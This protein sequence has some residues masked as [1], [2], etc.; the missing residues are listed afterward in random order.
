MQK[1]YAHRSFTLK[2]I[3]IYTQ[4]DAYM[5][6]RENALFCTGI[7]CIIRAKRWIVHIHTHTHSKKEKKNDR[8]LTGTE[9]LQ[10]TRRSNAHTLQKKKKCNIQR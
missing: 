8:K 6:E 10:R 2:Y 7:V 3:S 4:T 1:V 9:K 5:R